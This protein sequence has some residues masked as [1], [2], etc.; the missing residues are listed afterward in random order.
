MRL[1]G[2]LL[3]GLSHDRVAL[4]E[5][6]MV[7][8]ALPRS[9][10]VRGEVLQDRMFRAGQRSGDPPALAAGLECKNVEAE[11]LGG[12]GLNEIGLLGRFVD[13]LTG[14]RIGDLQQS[15][16]EPYFDEAPVGAFLPFGER[17]VVGIPGAGR[18]VP[19]RTPIVATGRVV[20]P[21][22]AVAI[23]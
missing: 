1:A 21:V 15:P 14:R 18:S 6:E 11:S 13:D 20:G 19:E 16:R 10:S 5:T 8:G 17:A 2:D 9:P 22:A 4:L 23:A 7:P 3:Q 12:R